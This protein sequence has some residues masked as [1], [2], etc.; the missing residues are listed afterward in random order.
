L[1][2]DDVTTQADRQRSLAILDLLHELS[3]ERQVILFSQEDDVLAW[4]EEHLQEPHDR[5]V[6]L[7]SHLIVI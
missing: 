4:G 2:L 7:D 1:V 5:L 6:R 3:G